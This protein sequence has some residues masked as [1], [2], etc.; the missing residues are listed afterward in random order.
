MNQELWE[1]KVEEK[2]YRGVSEQN[3]L[4]ATALYFLLRMEQTAA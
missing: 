1:Y 4:N 3:I 2:L